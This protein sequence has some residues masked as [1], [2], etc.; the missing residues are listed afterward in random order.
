MFLKV[1]LTLLGKSFQVISSFPNPQGVY[2][3]RSAL[4]WDSRNKFAKHWLA[5]L[6]LSSTVPHWGPAQLRSTLLL[7]AGQHTLPSA[8]SAQATNTSSQAP[9]LSALCQSRSFPSSQAQLHRPWPHL[10]TSIPLGPWTL[11]SL[12]F[13]EQPLKRDTPEN[14]GSLRAP[15]TQHPMPHQPVGWLVGL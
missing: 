14:L 7:S 13:I 15:E 9:P 1:E 3:S 11:T 6:G 8:H 10:L 4:Q 2:A 5:K 12:S